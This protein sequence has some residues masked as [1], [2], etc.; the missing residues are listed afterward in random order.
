MDMELKAGEL[1]AARSGDG[2][3]TGGLALRAALRQA[4]LDD[5]LDSLDR[6]Q[7]LLTHIRHAVQPRRDQW[8]EDPARENF[9]LLLAFHMGS[10]V[11]LHRREAI[12]WMSYADAQRVLPPDL[13]PEPAP[14]SRVLGLMPRSICLPLGVL[15]E[16][17]FSDKPSIG[18]RAYVQRLVARA[19][20]AAEALAPLPEPVAILRV[21][22][23]RI[24][25]DPLPRAWQAA[26]ERAGFLAACGMSLAARGLPVPPLDEAPPGAPYQV[27]VDRSGAAGR[28][29]LL[30]DLRC[31]RGK[32]ADTPPLRAMVVCP[33][34]AAA[35]QPIVIHSPKLV[36]CSAAPSLFP[37]LFRHFYR[38]VD[39][40]GLDGFAWRAHLDERA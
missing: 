28:D 3:V 33:F 40:C 24:V 23:A 30:V 2:E 39:D 7:A 14:W 22:S 18:C 11:S 9:L 27:T 13:R 36:A 25:G 34:R 35:G 19:G 21:S 17:L 37:E 12:R 32:Q 1:L 38:G 8:S 16:H 26:T 5:T 29:A 10:L 4:R 20:P 31:L 15:E 6:M